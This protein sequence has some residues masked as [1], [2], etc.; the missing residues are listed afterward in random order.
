VGIPQEHLQRIFDPYFTTKEMSSIK[1][2]G[3]G[4]AVAYSIIKNHDGYI[5]VESEVGAGTTFHI[6]LPAY[7][8]EFASTQISGDKG[9]RS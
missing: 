4:L 2:T 8:E 9:G 1:G 7:T 5:G 3:L 6:Y